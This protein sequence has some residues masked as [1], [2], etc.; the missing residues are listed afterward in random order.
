MI[1]IV[2]FGKYKE[3]LT[4]DEI[5]EY[6]MLKNQETPLVQDVTQ[7]ELLFERFNDIAGCNTGAIK[8]VKGKAVFLTYRWD[9]E[10]Y[11]DKLFYNSPIIWD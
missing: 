8:K 5:K 7:A 6:L 10:R 1:D 4:S 11:S 2:K 9:V 3:G